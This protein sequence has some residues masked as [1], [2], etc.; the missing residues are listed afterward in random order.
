MLGGLGHAVD[1][2]RRAESAESARVSVRDRGWHRVVEHLIAARV[3]ELMNPSNT[4]EVPL[5]IRVDPLTGDTGRLISGSKLAP[6]TP[7]GHLDADRRRPVSVRSVPIGSTRHRPLRP[8]LTDEGRI[9]RGSAVVFL[10]VLA[11]SESPR[12][13]IYAA[14]RTSSTCPSSADAGRQPAGGDSVAYTAAVHRQ[15]PVWSSINANYLPPAGSSWCTCTA[16]SAHDAVGTSVQR[17]LVG[18]SDAWPGGDDFWT[19]LVGQSAAG[20]RWI[21]EHGRVAVFK[22][23]APVG[24][25]RGVGGRAGRTRLEALTAADCADLGAAISSVLATY[26]ALNLTS[27]N[28]AITAAGRTRRAVLAAVQDRQPLQRRADVPQ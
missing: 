22:P 17:R 15:Q 1:G 5:R 11:Y 10:D 20:E 26:R 8:A 3:P 2:T 4:I 6:T 21:T 24:L 23:W 12:S 27:F 16:Q 13:G 25:P 28:W 9:E 14:D 18:R 7:S 19:S